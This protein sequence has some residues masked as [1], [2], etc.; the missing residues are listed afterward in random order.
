MANLAVPPV[1]VAGIAYTMAHALTA[2]VSFV[3][4]GTILPGMSGS[5]QPGR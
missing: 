3:A 5:C 4:F 1:D 2:I